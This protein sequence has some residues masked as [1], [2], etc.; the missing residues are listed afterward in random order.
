MLDPRYVRWSIR[1]SFQPGETDLVGSHGGLSESTWIDDDHR[2][3]DPVPAAQERVCR[4]LELQISQPA[5]ATT[6]AAT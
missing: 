2:F 4:A 6:F 1:P 5:A 3:V